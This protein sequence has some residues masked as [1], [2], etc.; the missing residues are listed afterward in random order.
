[1]KMKL[2]ITKICTAALLAFPAF[3]ARPVIA[4]DSS[5]LAGSVALHGLIGSDL[6]N[7]CFGKLRDS[8][9][10]N[11]DEVAVQLIRI[12]AKYH[13]PDLVSVISGLVECHPGCAALV[14]AEANRLQPSKTS[15]LVKAAAMAAPGHVGEIVEVALYQFP[16]RCQIIVDSAADAVPSH[17]KD[18]LKAVSLACI[19]LKPI[20]DREI[21][22]A[23]CSRAE[24]VKNVVRRSLAITK[25]KNPMG[26]KVVVAKESA[27]SEDVVTTK[28]SSGD[29]RGISRSP[30]PMLISPIFGPPPTPL[31]ATPVEIGVG[32]GHA[33]T[34]GG[35][36]YSGP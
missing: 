23:D 13:E 19:D 17:G 4:E 24:N 32:Q 35:R 7:V 22:S 1:M 36:D 11:R 29:P 9:L 31:P 30:V 3:Y 27:D 5:A 6:V 20:I 34:P 25:Q 14:V 33:Q 16:E 26:V 15:E 28:S 2:R 10:T 12:V 21:I 18:I 8:A